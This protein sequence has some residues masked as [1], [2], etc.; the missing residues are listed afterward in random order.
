[1]VYVD[2][3]NLYHG[4]HD[5]FGRATLWLD[6]VEL[7]RSLRPKQELVHVRYFT[8]PVLNDPGAQS[9]QAT[10]VSALEHRYPHHFKPVWGATKRSLRSCVNAG[11][12]TLGSRRRKQT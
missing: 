3:F 8:A 4:M 11:A 9:R 10:Y 12:G 2:G 6:L 1:M 7:A 5:A